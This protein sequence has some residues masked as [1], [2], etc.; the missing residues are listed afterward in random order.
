MPATHAEICR[1]PGT[2]TVASVPT[3]VVV[4]TAAAPD[5]RAGVPT[6]A[7]AAAYATDMK[8]R[9][10]AVLHAAHAAGCR[11]LVLGQW[12]CGVFKNDPRAVA[13]F[14]VEALLSPEWRFRFGTVVFAIPRGARGT[15]SQ[16]FTNSLNRLTRP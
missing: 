6:G 5:L 14:F 4:L 16:I 8:R 12:G 13:S 3:P 1:E 9:V 7:A 11:D 15:T 10:R 2:Y